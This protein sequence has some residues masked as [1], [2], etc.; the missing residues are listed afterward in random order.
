MSDRRWDRSTREVARRH[1]P[2][3]SPLDEVARASSLADE[4]VAFV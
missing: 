3:M 2:E 1:S 4:A